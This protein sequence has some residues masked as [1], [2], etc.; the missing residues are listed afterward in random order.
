VDNTDAYTKV[1]SWQARL[2][3]SISGGCD[4]AAILNVCPLI[5]NKTS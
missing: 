5:R 2:A 4:A 1:M 3:T